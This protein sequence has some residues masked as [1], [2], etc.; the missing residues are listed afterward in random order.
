MRRF[1]I[2]LAVALSLV[3]AGIAAREDR[4]FDRLRELAGKGAAACGTVELRDDPTAA[5]S[6]ARSAMAAG[7]PFWVAAQIEGIDSLLWRGV[8]L[9]PDKTVWL[10]SYDS[11]VHGGGGYGGESLHQG[12]CRDVQFSVERRIYCP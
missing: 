9:E 10:L 6:C 2:S 1:A 5:F 8:A 4:L 12:F 7:Q 3:S 11:D